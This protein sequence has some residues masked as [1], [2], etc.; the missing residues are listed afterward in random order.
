MRRPGMTITYA[1]L[2]ARG[3][4][5]GE[6]RGGA[7]AGGAA[8]GG[9]RDAGGVRGAGGGGPRRTRRLRGAAGGFHRRAARRA[10]GQRGAEAA[11]CTAAVFWA[12][13]SQLGHLAFWDA[14]IRP[15]VSSPA[16]AD[17]EFYKVSY[18]SS[19]P[20]IRMQAATAIELAN[21]KTSWWAASDGGTSDGVV[22]HQYREY[23][24]L[25]A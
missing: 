13:A 10:A 11:T 3:A 2:G 6:G 12:S 21:R 24:P 1:H 16:S 18:A 15:H 25:C 23:T 9:R 19:C 5:E 8:A 14:V 22:N 17:V 20:A 4:A 7:A